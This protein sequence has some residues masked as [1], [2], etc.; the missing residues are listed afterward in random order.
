MS[1]SVDRL[2]TL[3]TTGQTFFGVAPSG[4]I[5]ARYIR[6]GPV[7]LWQINQMIDAPHQG[8][9][10]CWWL[11]VSCDEGCAPGESCIAG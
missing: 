9:D 1:M 6:F 3:I 7:M 4:V 2:Q 11:K 5:L 8:S 10:L